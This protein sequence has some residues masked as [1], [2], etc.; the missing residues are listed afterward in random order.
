MVTLRVPHDMAIKPS[1]AKHIKASAHCTTRR[2]L[3]YKTFLSEAKALKLLQ[4]NPAFLRDD[5]IME[6]WWAKWFRDWDVTLCWLDLEWA[7][8]FLGQAV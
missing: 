4:R 8:L 2:K 7:C 3:S 6:S 1:I 5:V